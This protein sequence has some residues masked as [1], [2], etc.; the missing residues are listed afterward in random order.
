MWGVP[1]GGIMVVEEGD[2]EAMAMRLL[3]DISGTDGQRLER[4]AI[5]LDK[6]KTAF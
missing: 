4:A 2:G 5:P 6:P 3:R 1:S